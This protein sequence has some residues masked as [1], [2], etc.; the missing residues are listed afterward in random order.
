VIAGAVMGGVA[1]SQ[2]SSAPASTGPEA[3]SARGL[4]LGADITLGIGA[5]CAIAGIVVTVVQLTSAPSSETAA[6][7]ILPYGDT[8]GGGVLAT[9]HF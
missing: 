5:A 2:A 3:D 8:T 1:L 6:L 4:A 9:G 7:E